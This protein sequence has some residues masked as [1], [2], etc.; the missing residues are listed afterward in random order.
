M[1]N[2][3]VKPVSV[4]EEVEA[5]FLEGTKPLPEDLKELWAEYN[6][7]NKQIAVAEARKNVIKQIVGLQADM[8][9]VS[10]FTVDGVNSLGFNFKT[11]T[12]VDRKKLESKYP[13]VFADVTSTSESTVFYSRK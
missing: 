4:Q 3:E 2:T 1:K 7:L 13:D 6:E 12:N 8:E 11:T 5:A 9:G 10:M